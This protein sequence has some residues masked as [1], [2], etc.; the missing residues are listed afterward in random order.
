MLTRRLSR[1][2][3]IVGLTPLAA[4]DAF[5]PAWFDFMDEV[6]LHSLARAEFI[7]QPSGYDFIQQRPVVVEQPKLHDPYDF[8]LAVTEI[9]GVFY[10]LPAGMFE[11]FPIEPGIAVD[12]SGT[13]LDDVRQAPREGYVTDAP[14]PLRTDWVYIV[15]IRRDQAGCQRYGKFDVAA[16]GED[17]TVELRTIRNPLC[18]DRNLVPPGR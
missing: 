3:L 5:E 6:E 2:L 9:D 14:V 8:D 13:E 16:L 1:L 12:S 4:C 17:G 7:G 15:Q 10:A 11:G 18:N